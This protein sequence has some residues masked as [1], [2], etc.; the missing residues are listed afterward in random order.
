MLIFVS[1]DCKPTPSILHLD[2]IMKNQILISVIITSS[3]SFNNWAQA[4]LLNEKKIEKLQTNS[5]IS[6]DKSN[7]PTKKAKYY[8]VEETV[9]MKFGGHKTVYNVTDLKLIQFFDLA[10]NSTRTITP[11][12]EENEQL[13]K[14]SIKS[15]GLNKTENSTKLLIPNTPRKVDLNN[16]D[17]EN[18][19]AVTPLVVVPKEQF[20]ETTLKLNALNKIENSVKSPSTNISQKVDINNLD[21]ENKKTETPLV[22]APKEK[23]N[24]TAITLNTLNKIENS[25]KLS[26][27][28]KPKKV[29]TSAFVD[30]IKTYERVV[31][32]G[33]EPIEI[34]KKLA[35]SYFFN[36]ELEKSEKYYGKLFKKT[37]DLEP[38]YYYRYSAALR[39][40]GQIEMADQ[41][42]KKFNELSEDKSK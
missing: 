37:T 23:L 16:L 25:N 30:I 3:F 31:E 11:V 36:N 40:K 9:Q 19:E 39:S 27:S 41:Y 33:Y 8:H 14:T 26:I 5:S 34:L 1:V 18:K 29:D 22:P 28:D 20:D 13:A 7:A 32:K 21:Q 4:S 12:F 10:P 24:Q 42:L 2:I 17:Q 6:N 38:E 35:D 15:V